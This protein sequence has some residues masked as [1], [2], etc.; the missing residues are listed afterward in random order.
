MFISI[1][2]PCYNVEK[3]VVRT[4]NSVLSQ[5][6]DNSRF[7]IILVNDGST[8]STSKRIKQI[9]LNVPQ[10]VFLEQANKGVSIARNLGLSVAKGEYVY[11]LDADDTISPDFIDSLSQTAPADVFL[12]GYQRLFPN[13]KSKNYL[14]FQS[15]DHLKDY[16]LNRQNICCASSIIFKR[17]FLEEHNLCFSPGTYYGEDRELV[18]RAL[19]HAQTIGVIPKVLFT[20]HDNPVSATH[21]SYSVRRLTS[22]YAMERS[23]QELCETR[24]EPYMFYALCITIMY[25]YGNYLKTVPARSL[26]SQFRPYLN[27]LHFPSLRTFCIN[28]YWIGTIALIALKYVNKTLFEAF[29]KK[30]IN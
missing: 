17:S 16:L 22:L 27:R 3:F 1:I 11:F 12:V 19:F 8:D 9:A 7:E 30:I 13:G 28:R 21:V 18:R 15:N 6:G 10:I 14:P 25:N 2:I 24:Y 23:Y 5:T 20:Y 29:L 26:E 4:I